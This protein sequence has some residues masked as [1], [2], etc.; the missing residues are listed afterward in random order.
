VTTGPE[1][2]EPGEQPRW[3]QYDSQYDSQYGAPYSPPQAVAMHPQATTALVLGIVGLAGTF[4]CGIAVVLGPFAWVIGARAKRE[5]A[6][7][8]G[9]FRGAGEANVGMILGIITT[10]LLVLAILA[11]V[12]FLLLF[13]V[14]AAAGSGSGGNV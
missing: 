13:V 10:V 1:S 2:P 4:L 11:I 5:I 7:A 14:F 3:Q 9:H 6:A 12:G 8:P